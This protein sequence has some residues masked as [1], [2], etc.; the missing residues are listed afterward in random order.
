[1]P[2]D[3]TRV[4]VSSTQ[5]RGTDFI[6]TLPREIPVPMREN[7]T[8]RVLQEALRLVKRGWCQGVH[9]VSVGFPISY[10]SFFA[11]RY[12]VQG[13]I[14]RAGHNLKLPTDLPI[15]VMTDLIRGYS[16]EGSIA[17]WNDRLATTHQEVITG[18]GCGI[19]T[20]RRL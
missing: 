17:S 11:T 19:L 8:V 10:T 20:A 7:D 13:A 5:A 14:L 15:V 3:G 4:T 1:M 6:H 9:A 12:C 2:F 16:P 18:L